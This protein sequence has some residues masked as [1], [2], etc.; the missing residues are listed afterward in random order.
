M[1]DVSAGILQNGDDNLVSYITHSRLI[2]KDDPQIHSLQIRVG[3]PK[4]IHFYYLP[5]T[6]TLLTN[7]Q[8]L[9][10][11]SL[12]FSTRNSLLMHGMQS[13]HKSQ[14]ILEKAI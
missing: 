14:A 6:N 2:F 7:Y 9:T 12:H 13:Y 1:N 3:S 8:G 5:Q 10:Y 11:Y 4:G